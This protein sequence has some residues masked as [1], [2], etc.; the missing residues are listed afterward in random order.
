MEEEITFIS[1]YL[2]NPEQKKTTTTK[3]TVKI[4][5][6]K[7]YL[8]DHIVCKLCL[9]WC[10]PKSSTKLLADIHMLQS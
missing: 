10:M 1:N 8:I 2:G 4:E 7:V 9:I 6:K 3:T 5:I